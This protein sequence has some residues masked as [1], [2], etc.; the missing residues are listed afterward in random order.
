MISCTTC[1]QVHFCDVP[2]KMF[3]LNFIVRE[4]E[5]DQIEGHSTKIQTM[6]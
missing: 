4:D 2:A 5:R 1:K 6:I 3:N